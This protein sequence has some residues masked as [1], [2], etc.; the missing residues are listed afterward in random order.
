MIAYRAMLDVPRELALYLSR[1]LH[2]ERR[3]RGTRKNSRALT[4]FRHAV[5]GLRWFRQN[6]DVP[7]LA[8]D[9]GI[10]RATGYRY[11][12]E[13]VI[14]LAE[15]APDLHEA[16]QRAKDEGTAYVIL[17][18]KVFSADRCSEKTLSVKGEPID[19]WY[20]GK[21]REH[22]GNIQAL[23][24]PDGFPWWVSDV[25][26][27]SLHDLTVAREHV[28]GA[29]YW[30]ASHLDLPT[31]ADG[32]YDGAGIGVHTP[33]KQPADGQVLDVDT[34]TRNAL[35]RGLRCLGERGFALLTE[36]WRSL[37]HLTANPSKIGDI[38]KAALVLTH[39]EHGKIA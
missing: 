5:L 39:F 37:R 19:L 20:S 38:I 2:A 27:G 23:C 24:A 34:R 17:D 3:R 30:A 21:A 1:L 13:V 9:H 28:L 22:G 14:V 18:G 32:G 15:Q 7:A 16:L 10:S 35:L 8:R 6:T 36:R 31:L 26:P 11:L 29:L 12:D 33:V 4:C 25:E